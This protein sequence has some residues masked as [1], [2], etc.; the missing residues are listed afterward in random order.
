MEKISKH[1]VN[2]LILDVVLSILKHKNVHLVRYVVF[3]IVHFVQFR[4][5]VHLLKVEFY[6]SFSFLK[7]FLFVEEKSNVD[8]LELRSVLA[9]LCLKPKVKCKSAMKNSSLFGVFCKKVLI[10]NQPSLFYIN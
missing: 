8:S 9:Y 5:Y 4:N 2:F 1:L 7:L 6:F 10:K 3:I